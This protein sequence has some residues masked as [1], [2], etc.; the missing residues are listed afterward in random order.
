[1]T[2]PTILSVVLAGVA[3]FIF[4]QGGCRADKEYVLNN[5]PV[6][7]IQ[8]GI[9]QGR[10]TNIST[11]EPIA[12]A[13]VTLDLGTYTV[14]S[15]TSGAGVYGFSGVPSNQD[16]EWYSVVV[17][18]GLVS[19]SIRNNLPRAVYGFV[20]LQAPE[21]YS[22]GNGSVIPLPGISAQLDFEYGMN[23]G[24]MS[25]TMRDAA[26]GEALDLSASPRVTVQA[27]GM[28]M[29]GGVPQFDRLLYN[30]AQTGR[31]IIAFEPVT[32][33]ADNQGDFLVTGL[34]EG[35]HY[36]ATFNATGYKTA[37]GLFFVMPGLHARMP[38]DSLGG[39]A[40][41]SPET[42]LPVEPTAGGTILEHVGMFK[43]DVAIDNYRPVCVFARSIAQDATETE[44][45]DNE[46]LITHHP[47]VPSENIVSMSFTFSE[48][49]D[50]ATSAAFYLNGLAGVFDDID[51]ETRLPDE[52]HTGTAVSLPA[53]QSWDPAGKVLT[54]SFTGSPLGGGFV[55]TF[56]F[57][58]LRDAGG[59]SYNGVLD[60]TNPPT[61]EDSARDGDV[62]HR[63]PLAAF[64]F[65]TGVVNELS[66]IVAGFTQIPFTAN[67][68][69]D[70]CAFTWG[71]MSNARGYILQVNYNSTFWVD[72][73]TTDIHTAG[74]ALPTGISFPGETLSPTSGTAAPFGWT[75]LSRLLETPP[76]LG[77]RLGPNDWDFS[78]GWAFLAFRV[79]PID[80]SGTPQYEHAS[81][82]VIPV[83]NTP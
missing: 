46:K 48:P 65:S 70:L 16:N 51:F 31:A 25:G 52:G 78:D 50:T 21:D 34:Y 1:M 66:G 13:T 68:D 81:N 44:L 71:S 18:H 26:S 76:D 40:P 33:T 30:F 8:N 60:L 59:H 17:T 19:S 36:Y 12:W 5:Y 47:T 39:P 3:V 2:R 28:S 58:G 41:S 38:Q 42:Y 73:M 20:R 61:Q 4:A 64:R 23:I 83:D 10:I 56:D 15:Y 14:V 72:S 29:E 67:E 6:S 22:P 77:A 9:I 63:N 24:C 57:S 55:Y 32:I 74:D 53:V 69:N 27:A 7:S 45:K 35:S 54:V 80:E 62:L 79:V 49:M 75:L 82:P 37:E 11:G 43:D